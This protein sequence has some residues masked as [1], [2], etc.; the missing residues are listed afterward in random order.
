[1]TIQTPQGLPFRLGSR[2]LVEHVDTKAWAASTR[3]EFDLRKVG[4]LDGLLVRLTGTLT[5]VTGSPDER[6]GFPYN[7]IR[8]FVLNVPGLAHPI[9]QSGYMM[10]MQNLL[11]YD[12]GM[13]GRG[14]DRTALAGALANAYHDAELDER[15]AIAVAANDWDLWWYVPSHRNA[16]DLRGIMPIGGEQDTTLEVHCGALADIFDTVANVSATAL[17]V[18]VY[19]VFHTAPIAGAA[20]PDTT[21]A[22]VL[23]EYSQSFSATGDQKIDIPRDG[24]ILNVIHAIWLDDDLYPPAPEANIETLSLRVNR[25]KLLD[26]VPYVAWA[27][28]Q[29]MRGDFPLPAGVLAYDFDYRQADIPFVNAAGEVQPEWLHSSSATEI[30]SLIRVASGATLDAA[31][32]VTSVKRLMRV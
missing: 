5:G 3:L 13:H 27:K 12:F 17:N 24:I 9:Q 30:E 31:K 11:G 4:Y 7:I 19:Q 15:Y 1:M 18:E 2:Q 22:V 29:A 6:P 28:L 8:Q 16:R 10:K 25:D 14:N 20:S 23:D 21:W 26:A 32:I